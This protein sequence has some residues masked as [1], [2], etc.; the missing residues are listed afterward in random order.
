MAYNQEEIFK[1]AL[2]LIEKEKLF[3]IEDIVAFLPCDKSTFYRFFPLESNEYDAIKDALYKSRI[4]I[5]SKLRNNWQ[6]GAPALQLAL[7]KL[8]STPE[9]LKKLSMQ[10]IDHTTNGKEI[11]L[12]REERDEKIAKIAAKIALNKEN[13]NG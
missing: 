10:Q 5:K 13:G 6:E 8:A 4:K 12:S 3:F 9:E 11:T 2:K 1:T 7:Y